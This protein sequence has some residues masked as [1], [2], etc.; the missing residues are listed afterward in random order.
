MKLRAMKD[1]V[2][3]VI[4]ESNHPDPVCAYRKFRR[5]YYI[6]YCLTS[7]FF[8]FVQVPITVIAQTQA[9]VDEAVKL[10][11]V[12]EWVVTVPP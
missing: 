8:Y 1:I 11:D 4:S 3:I 2:N 5:S 10:L 6:N 12:G 7:Y 9:A